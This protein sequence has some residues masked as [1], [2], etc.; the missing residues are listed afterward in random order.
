MKHPRP[1]LLTL[2]VAPTLVL[3]AVTILVAVLGWNALLLLGGAIALFATLS[4]IRDAIQ[5][6]AQRRK[7]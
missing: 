2:F 4:V 7:V 5:D 1:F 3:T 6:F